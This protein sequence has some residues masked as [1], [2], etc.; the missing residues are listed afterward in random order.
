MSQIKVPVWMGL[1]VSMTCLSIALLFNNAAFVLKHTWILG[2]LGCLITLRLYLS[3][4]HILF[5]FFAEDF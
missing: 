1:G 4:V 2:W 5:T 3:F